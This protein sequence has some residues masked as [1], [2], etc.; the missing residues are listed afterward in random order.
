MRASDIFS[1]T[2]GNILQ[3]VIETLSFV[4]GNWYKTPGDMFDVREL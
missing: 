2:Q 4:T 1:K 3:P